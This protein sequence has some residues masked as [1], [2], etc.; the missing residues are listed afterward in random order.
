MLLNIIFLIAELA[1]FSCLLLHANSYIRRFEASDFV[2]F[3][4]KHMVFGLKFDFKD[5]IFGHGPPNDVYNCKN[6]FIISPSLMNP[7]HED[8]YYR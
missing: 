7:Q 2:C 8:E 3:K 6:I 1:K 5:P 4:L